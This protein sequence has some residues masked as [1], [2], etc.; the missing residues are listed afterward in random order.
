MGF[1][2][3][4]FL[5][6][7]SS[8][9]IIRGE[10]LEENKVSYSSNRNIKDSVFR[11]L[12]DDEANLL[13]LFNALEG[14][15]CKDKDVI[16]INTLKGAIFNKVKNDL[17]F[18]VEAL[19]LNLVEHQSTISENAPLRSYLY[20]GQ[21]YR[22][23]L[24]VGKVYQRKLYK[25]PTPRL[26]VLYNGVEDF[27]L[28][29]VQRFSNAFLVEQGQ[30]MV[31]QIVKTININWEKGHPI[32]QECPVLGE[33]SLFIYK[34]RQK[35]KNGLNRDLAVK[36]AVLECVEEGVLK[37]FLS[38]HGKEVHEMD[39]FDITYEEFLKIRVDEAREDGLEEGMEKGTEK[40]IA[41]LVLDYR[42]EGFSQE[43]ILRK[44]QKHFGL[45]EG[46]AK[47]YYE[48]YAQ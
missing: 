38:R 5:C 36:E 48:Q 6:D 41:G 43:K 28:E 33:Y 30:P 37:E 10:L 7:D 29:K 46:Q 20:L 45:S 18:S 27:P 44:L 2:E 32:L 13:S 16:Q 26:Y 4:F 23:I 12:F 42:E 8:K 21:V 31:Q 3:K 24:D 34:I 9:F 22:Q 40:G 39:F 17:S 47:A 19:Y 15:D 1:L 14:T 25:V 11:L 35:L